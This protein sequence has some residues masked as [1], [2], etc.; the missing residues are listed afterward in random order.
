[1]RDNTD[2]PSHLI[3][4]SGQMGSSPLGWSCPGLIVSPV[5]DLWEL[6]HQNQATWW[7][8]LSLKLLVRCLTQTYHLSTVFCE[9]LS[10]EF[11]HYGNKQVDLS[12]RWSSDVFLVSP[13]NFLPLPNLS[14]HCLCPA[15]VFKS[16]YSHSSLE[17]AQL[18]SH[19]MEHKLIVC[20]GGTLLYLHLVW[21]TT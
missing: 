1:M 6:L 17:A 7:D 14:L 16:V 21:P 13:F 5:R 3:W 11:R 20:M 15:T 10:E 19:F 12:H 2:S 4:D 8:K 18:H 9:A